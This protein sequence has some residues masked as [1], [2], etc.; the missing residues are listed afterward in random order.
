M[1]ALPSGADTL[2]LILRANPKP[3]PKPIT[4]SPPATVKPG[5]TSKG[6]SGNKLPAFRSCKQ[7]AADEARFERLDQEKN[8]SLGF[9]RRS[10]HSEL[11]RRGQPKTPKGAN[12]LCAADGFASNDVDSF[13]VEKIQNVSHATT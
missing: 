10:P 9:A 2:A 3:K 12:R 8:E 4:N 11:F 6:P 1:F 5:P 7:L 13:G